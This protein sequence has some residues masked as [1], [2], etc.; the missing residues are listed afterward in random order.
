MVS[1]AFRRLATE[2]ASTKRNAGTAGAYTAAAANLSNLSIH[3]L[4][5]IT[6]ELALMYAI[7]SPRATWVTYIEDDTTDIVNGDIMTVNSTDYRVRAVG[8]WVKMD[9]LEIILEAISG[10]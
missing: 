1:A 9:Y 2:T 8:K 6:A 10:T 4:A 3:E 5:P 7:E